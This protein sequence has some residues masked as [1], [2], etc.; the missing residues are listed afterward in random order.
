M[1]MA[2]CFGIPHLVHTPRT[3]ST[4]VNASGSMLNLPACALL[5]AGVDVGQ[6]NATISGSAQHMWRNDQVICQL[7]Q[8]AERGCSIRQS[9]CAPWIAT[10]QQHTMQGAAAVA[11]PASGS[12]QAVPCAWQW[13]L[14][15]PAAC[16]LH[17]RARRCRQSACFAVCGSLRAA[18]L[19]LLSFSRNTCQAKQR[20]GAGCSSATGVQARQ[21]SKTE[22]G[23][24]AT[25][26][27]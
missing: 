1:C 18:H 26:T 17:A 23:K 22:P 7:Q 25:S 15:P 14:L 19:H 11:L 21:A 13:P 9:H 6:A 12:A 8:A 10:G 2:V 24:H 20:Q 3:A 16:H 5:L 27:A 4:P